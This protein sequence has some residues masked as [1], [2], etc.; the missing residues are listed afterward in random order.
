MEILYFNYISS[1]S[2]PRKIRKTSRPPLVHKNGDSSLLTRYQ[3][4]NPIPGASLPGFRITFQGLSQYPHH[5]R[6][7]PGYLISPL[8]TLRLITPHSHHSQLQAHANSQSKTSPQSQCVPM[9]LR[10]DNSNAFSSA[11]L[12]STRNGIPR[13]QRSVATSSSCQLSRLI[14]VLL[15][16]TV[17]GVARL[18]RVRLR[19]LGDGDHS[20]LGPDVNGALPVEAFEAA[21]FYG[22][23]ILALYL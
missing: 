12:A 23:D 18:L 11:Q 3:D 5:H 8:L 19:A 17:V 20:G 2:Y 9:C 13:L 14:Q 16:R 1:C 15:L 4:I 10:D 7:A 6:H 21:T 22:D